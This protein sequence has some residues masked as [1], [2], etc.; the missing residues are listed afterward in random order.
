MTDKDKHSLLKLV[1]GVDRMMELAKHDA[2]FTDIPSGILKT[3]IR[4]ILGKMRNSILTK[5]ETRMSDRSMLSEILEH[6][7][8]VTAPR[9]V[10]VINATGVIIH[11][12][13]GRSLLCEDALNNMKSVAAGYSNLEFNIEKGK[14]GIRYS[15]VENILCELTGASAAMAVNNNAGAVL[16]CLDTM[17]KGKEVLVSRGELVEIGGSF[18]IPDVM[19]KSGAILK[20]VGATNRTHLKDYQAG[21]SDNT[22]LLLKV[23]T[24]NYKIQGFTSSVSLKE[25]VELGKKTD[26]PVM[27]DLGSGTLIDLSKYGLGREPTVSE[28]LKSGADIVTFSGDKLLGGPQTGI[29]AGNRSAIEKIKSNPLTR[30]LRIDKL[31]LA[32]LESTLRLYRDE[33]T[34]VKKIPTLRMLTQSF[35]EITSKAVK[36]SKILKKAVKNMA[37][38]SLMDLSS[39]SGGGAFPD[40]SLPTKCILVEPSH[41]SAAHLERKMRMHRPSIIGRI[42]NDR[43]IMDPRTIQEGEEMIISRALV[44]ILTE[45]E[46]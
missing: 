44:K 32:A 30:A 31:T 8:S 38:I 16:L 19:A 42:E 7:C 20:E 39:M 46:K 35:E 40:L 1:P 33:S 4:H 45:T 29:I 11:T 27:Q 10:S 12:N 17:A 14:R 21:I 24:S 2:R 43:F 34:A 18:R 22:G 41:M 23:H 13:L 5:G 9:L 28:S 37:V 6:V 3:S 26:I 15:A 25:L 36:I